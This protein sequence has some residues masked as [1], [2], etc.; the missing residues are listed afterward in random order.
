MCDYKI[1]YTKLIKIILIKPDLIQSYKH[2]K[3]EH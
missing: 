2:Q 1:I 3:R